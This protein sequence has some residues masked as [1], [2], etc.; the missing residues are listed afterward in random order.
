LIL[1]PLIFFLF[2]GNRY[3]DN[4]EQNNVKFFHSD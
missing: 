3:K 2:A 4:S 1:T